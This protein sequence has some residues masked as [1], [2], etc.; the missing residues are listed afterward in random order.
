MKTAEW[1]NM[2]SGLSKRR[3]RRMARIKTTKIGRKT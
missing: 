1:K 2:K 3:S